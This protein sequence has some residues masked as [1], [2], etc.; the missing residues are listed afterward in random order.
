MKPETVLRAARLIKTGEVFELGRVLS[1]SMP[2]PAGRLRFYR[3]DTDGT[4]QFTGENQIDHTPKD[5][6]VRVYTGNA[7]DIVHDNTEYLGVAFAACL[8]TPV[9]HTVHFPLTDDRRANRPQAVMQNL[10]GSFA[11]CH[12]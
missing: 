10:D 12:P 5:E 1:E 9:L 7:F 2:L 3:R 8:P 6:T 4:L 11:Y